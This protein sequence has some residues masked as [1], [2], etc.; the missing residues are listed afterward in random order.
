MAEAEAALEEL[1]LDYRV[2]G[3]GTAVT[4]Q[5][6]KAN[7]TVAAGSEI[8]LYCGEEASAEQVEMLDL[9]GLDYETARIRMG[10]YGLYVKAEGTLLE[11]GTV[12]VVKQ[13]VEAGE[14][15]DV[16]TVVTVTLSDSSNLGRY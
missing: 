12:T 5:L 2:V 9:T 13:S 10:W 11:S 6:P 7:S 16:G 4:A 15:V 3:E 14:M 8:V 1:G